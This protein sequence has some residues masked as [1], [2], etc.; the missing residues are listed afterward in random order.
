[1]LGLSHSTA[2]KAVCV[3]SASVTGYGKGVEVSPEGSSVLSPCLD[4][5]LLVFILEEYAG[6]DLF[7]Q[8]G[9]SQ[10]PPRPTLVQKY[11]LLCKVSLFF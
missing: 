7:R 5:R 11:H 2:L 9:S 1:M 8:A 10:H 6:I 3:C 4:A